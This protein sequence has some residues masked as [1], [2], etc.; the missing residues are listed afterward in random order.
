VIHPRRRP[1]RLE[2]KEFLDVMRETAT[3]IP[4][5]GVASARIRKKLSRH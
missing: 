1:L 3:D 4:P 5:F 2:A